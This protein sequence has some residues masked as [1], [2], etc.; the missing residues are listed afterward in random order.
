[1]KRTNIDRGWYLDTRQTA[2][3][4]FVN[5]REARQVDLPHDLTIESDTT[6]DAE[7]GK[8]SGYYKGGL[9]YYTKFITI[10]EEMKDQRILIEIDGSYMNTEVYCDGNF[11]KR[12]PYGYTPFHADITPYVRFG[13][14]T[15]LQIIVNNQ[16]PY[17][18][19]W[20]TGSDFT[21]MLIS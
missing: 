6:P 9:A 8:A 4:D 20:Y 12:H 1:M 18:S 13:R 17:T 15:R 10:P 11:V 19:R 14:E 3:N 2:F 16:L 21:G 5:V 7:S